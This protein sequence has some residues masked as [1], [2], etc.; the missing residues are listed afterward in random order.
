MSKKYLVT[1]DLVQIY[2]K[3]LSHHL[4][5]KQAWKGIIAVSR[6]GLV[7]AAIVARELNIRNVDTVCIASYH[8]YQTQT[9]MQLLKQPTLDNSGEGYVIIDD[10]VDS[11]NTAKL[12]RQLYPNAYF[13]TIFAKPNGKPLVDFNVID[14]PQD[15]WIE[16]PWDTAVQFIPPIVS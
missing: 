7:P 12:I 6:G 1:W 4:H 11:G 9:D 16:Q 15:T 13:V 10:L 5:E 2:G 14:V 8:D 3:T